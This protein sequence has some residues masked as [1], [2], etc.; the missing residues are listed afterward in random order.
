MRI[1][2]AGVALLAL[3]TAGFS[4][5]AK[6]Q[7]KKKTIEYTNPSSGSEM[8]G[9]YCA[10]C[11]GVDGKGTGPAASALKKTP[12]NLTLLTKKNNGKFPILAIQ[13]MIQGDN[14]P[15][16]HGSRDMPMWGDIFRS[17]SSSPAVV[18]LRVRNLREYIQSLQEK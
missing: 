6:T 10:V 3:S 12:S 8:Y 9:A 15:S 16:A 18:E 17:V 1:L 4:Q 13:A 11:H 2:I 5:E 7:I 14:S